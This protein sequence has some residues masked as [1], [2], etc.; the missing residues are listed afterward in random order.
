MLPREK[1]GEK[2]MGVLVGDA[3]SWPDNGNEVRYEFDGTD[4]KTKEGENA[5]EVGIPVGEFLITYERVL[6]QKTELSFSV[7]F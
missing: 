5:D 3:I 7:E 1:L 2:K 6:D 4:W